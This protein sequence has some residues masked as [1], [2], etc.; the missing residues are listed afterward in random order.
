MTPKDKGNSKT[1]RDIQSSIQENP[2]LKVDARRYLTEFC[3]LEEGEELPPDLLTFFQD[4]FEA[5][6]EGSAKCADQA[7]GLTPSKRGRPPSDFYEYRS[8]ATKVLEARVTGKSHQIALEEVGERQD[9]GKTKVGEAWAKHKDSALYEIQFLRSI[10]GQG[11]L[12][13]DEWERVRIIYKDNPEILEKW[14]RD[15]DY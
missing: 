1:N 8:L 3:N 15:G 11:R 5:L 4:A 7:L 9:C 14:P 12:T 10:R 6:L 2:A 13:D